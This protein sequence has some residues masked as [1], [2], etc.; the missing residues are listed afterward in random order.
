MQQLPDL[1]TLSST[2]MG[3]LV[4]ELWAMVQTLM[5]QNNELQARLNLNSR[6]SSKPPSSDGLNKPQP[7]SLRKAG[8]RPVGGQKGH[9]G[10]TLSQVAEPNMVVIHAPPEHCDVWGQASL[11]EARQVHDL[12][13]LRYQVT[14]H[15]VLQSICNCG[16]TH[17][18]VF[19]AEV[20]A[21][22]QYGPRAKAAA[23][24]LNQYQMLPLKRTGEVMGDLFDMP[25]SEATI[26]SANAEAAQVLAPTVTA[27][28]QELVNRPI[29][30]ADETG[31]RVNKSLHWLHTLVTEKLTWLGRHEKRGMAAF[32][33][34][35]ILPLFKGTLVHDGWGSYRML[36]SR[37]SLCNAHHVR[38][39]TYVH[40]QLKQDWAGRSI[41]VLLYANSLIHQLRAQGQID[42]TAPEHL[43]RVCDLRSQ[44]EATLAEGDLLNPRVQ[45]NGRRGRIKQ[46]KAANLIGRLRDY[47]DDVWR[48]M[49]EPNVPFTNNLA[50]Q[51]VR[52][53]KVKQKIS[54]CFRT[55]DGADIYCII[56]SYLATLNKQGAK[57]FDALT[58][59]FLGSP[60]Q[61]RFG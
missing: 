25:M 35:G 13:D 29:V 11:V 55:S 44:F 2:Q 22:V 9:K 54:G 18:G 28:A 12:P 10:H 17:R 5:A 58:Q 24:H 46:S 8:Q 61:P 60:V 20:T 27:I 53:P 50:E 57:L 51:A 21:A 3:A 42:Y 23:V 38:E 37:H 26:L 39:L 49:T 56:R 59:A 7:K 33:E 52:M 32:I 15:R 48:F 1:S 45:S 19:P 31:L 14:E 41:E 43:Q 34:H 4:L 47:S 6:N 30:H 36:G 40:E 16:K